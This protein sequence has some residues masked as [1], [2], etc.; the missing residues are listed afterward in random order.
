MDI[1]CKKLKLLALALTLGFTAIA[2]EKVSK[3]IKETY[4]FNNSGELHIENKYGNINIYGWIKDEVSI[5][6]SITVTDKKRENAKEFLNRIIPVIRHS[7][8]FISVNYKIA[9]KNSGF[10]SNLFEKANPFDFDRGNVQID[11]KVYVPQKVELE[12]INTFG[13][14][15]IEDWVGVLMADVQHGDMW[16]SDNLNKA[17]VTMKYGKLRAKD[18]NYANIDIKNG[19]LDMDHA[20]TIRLNTSG[21]TIDVQLVES[22]ELYSN[23]DEVDIKEMGTL[24]GNLKFSKLR[25]HRL[26][27]DIDLNLKISDLWV[28]RILTPSSRISLDQ[29][30][31]EMNINIFNFPHEFSA[32]LEEGLVRLPKTFH[33]V[34]SKMLDKGKKLRE[35]KARYGKNGKGK[36]TI[37]GKKGVVLLKEI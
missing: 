11:Y 28:E 5:T 29:E 17:D 30:S 2:Q 1:L 16:M 18:I 15:F 32:T 21:S 14:V 7:D 3:E 25:I 35:I 33:N 22:L 13:D 31:S 10:F 23:K 26:K 12:I 6:V 8:K 19:G 27:K 4:T 9:D 34:D 36:I 24:Y 37:I 20:N